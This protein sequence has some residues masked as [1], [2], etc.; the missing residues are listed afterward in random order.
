MHKS[1]PKNVKDLIIWKNIKWLWIGRLKIVS[2]SMLP[3]IDLQLKCNI[4][5]SSSRLFFFVETDKVIVKLK[6]KFKEARIVKTTLRKKK[7]WET[8]ITWL[9]DSL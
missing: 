5:Q 8:Y 2:N 7:N 1:N 3:Q 9:Q 6:C 4:I